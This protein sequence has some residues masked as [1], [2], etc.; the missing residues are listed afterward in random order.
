MSEDTYLIDEERKFTSILEEMMDEEGITFDLVPPEQVRATIRACATRFMECHGE[1]M[2]WVQM[3]E[4]ER[5]M[6]QLRRSIAATSHT[7]I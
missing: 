7:T 5:T 3:D 6:L 2:E 1:L 4:R